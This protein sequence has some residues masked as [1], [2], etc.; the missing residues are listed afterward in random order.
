MYKV[1]NPYKDCH[2][3]DLNMI[4]VHHFKTG[5]K[6]AVMEFTVFAGLALTLGGIFL[7][8]FMPEI[9]FFAECQNVPGGDIC[10]ISIK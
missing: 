5:K 2:I 4:G 10:H 1:H 3:L 6:Q 7:A 8:S 9:G